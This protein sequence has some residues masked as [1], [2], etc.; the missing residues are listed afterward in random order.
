MT[1]YDESETSKL[2]LV[3]RRPQEGKTVLCINRIIQDIITN[4]IHLVLTM[5]T[6]A[7]SSQFLGRLKQEIGV[8][9]IIVL[10][11]NKHSAGG[12]HY[13]KDIESAIRIII[14]N[15]NIKVIV[16]CC[17]V[18]RFRESIP[19][20]LSCVED[21]RSLSRRNL[22]FVLHIDEAHKYI[23]ENIANIRSF[24]DNPLVSDIIGYTATPFGIWSDNPMDPLFH[25]ILICDLDK[26]SKLISS[27]KYFGVSNC[28]FISHEHLSE[29]DLVRRMLNIETEN[30]ETSIP[31]IPIPESVKKYFKNMENMRQSWYNNDYRFKLGNELLLLSFVDFI[32]PSLDIPEEEFS[33]NF[34]PAYTRKVTHYQSMELIHKHYPTSNVIVVNGEGIQ[35][36][37]LCEGTGDDSGTMVSKCIDCSKQVSEYVKSI[38]DENEK[39]RMSNA[40]MEP[41]FMVEHLIRNTRDFPT[42]VTGFESVGMSVTLISQS[43]GNFDNVVMAHQHY[44]GD[45]LYQLCRFLFNYER[46]NDENI[47][48]IKRTKFYSLRDIVSTTC[49]EYEVNTRRLYMEFAGK[50][51][52][53]RE[54]MGLDPLEPTEKEIKKV[55]LQSLKLEDTEAKKWKQFKVYDGNDDEQWE[56]VGLF[57]QEFRGKKLDKRSMLK[58]QGE[59]YVCSDSTDRGVKSLSS[60]KAFETEK[61]TSRFQLRENEI[62]YARLFVGYDNVDDPTEY[63][64]FIKYIRLENTPENLETLAKCCPPK[65]KGSTTSSDEDRHDSDMDSQ[66]L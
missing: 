31:E 7:S 13:A 63:T 38:E 17:H 50:A 45:K 25:K 20:L 42:F 40:L 23:P 5:N 15:K 55:N 2:S 65:K 66:E 58:K 12:C 43:L 52:S 29:Q 49:K 1:E 10:N 46:W 28:E 9:R 6:I 4:G 8:D 11:S 27:P 62:S 54:V 32:L 37:R 19:V 48:K 34:V 26:E 51:C 61:F 14:D 30:Q 60:I 36:F 18:K 59:F 64:I 3:C 57:Y 41:S 44:S 53:R 47:R 21:S 16:A 24:N 33:Y 35:L 39:K 22:K 56:K